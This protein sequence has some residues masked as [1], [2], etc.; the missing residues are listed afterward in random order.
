M[1]YLCGITSSEHDN[2]KELTEPIYDVIDG[3]I[4][5]VDDKC[6]EATLNLLEERKGKGEILH[7][8]WTNDHDL[9]MN[10]FLRKS[11]LQPNDWFILR[12]SMERF[13]PEWAAQ[14][15]QL[16]DT[17]SLNGINSVYNYGK[18]FAFKWNDS[19]IFQGSPHWG[20]QG[21]RPH[22]IDLAETL[23][24]DKH[25]HTWRIKDGEEG[26]RPIHNKIDHEAKYLWTYG[27]SNHAY[28]GV[29]FDNEMECALMQRAEMIRQ[30]AR[31]N[32]RYAECELNIE[33]L[34]KYLTQLRDDDPESLEGFVNSHRVWKNFYRFHFLE[35]DFEEIDKTENSWEYKPLT[36][37]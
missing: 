21:T 23:D 31:H 6:D 34:K 17:L 13:N 30:I 3:L 24:E 12:D 10:V 35:E 14:L 11:V 8:K 25:E 29:D 18:G 19:M 32:A 4:Y 26:G 22:A 36:L 9:Q 16:L 33:G 37:V 2:I 28:L 20:L 1:I 7:R 27:R 5:V 15:P